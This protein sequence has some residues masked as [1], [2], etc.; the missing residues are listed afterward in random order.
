MK[1]SIHI[2]SNLPVPHSISHEIVP[3]NQTS[4][5][6]IKASTNYIYTSLGMDLDY[7]LCFATLPEN[8]YEINSLDNKSELTY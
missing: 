7:I 3:F 1:P 6:D 5:Q 8:R 4:K 2:T